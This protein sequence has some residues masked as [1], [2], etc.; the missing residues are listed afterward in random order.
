MNRPDHGSDDADL[1]SRLRERL[2]V[3]PEPPAAMFERTLRRIGSRPGAPAT[4]SWMSAAGWWQALAAPGRFALAAA[5][6][7]VGGTIAF[8]TVKLTREHERALS[9]AAAP[10]IIS[11]DRVAPRTAQLA[12]TATIQ[13]TVVDVPATVRRIAAAARGAGGVVTAPRAADW[14]AQTANPTVRLTLRLP[15]A[16]LDAT[17]RAVA[18]F[19]S[20]RSRSVRSIDL[21]ATLRGTDLQ[22][23]ALRRSSAHT[24][25][26]LRADVHRKIAQLSAHRNALAERVANA[27]LA[28]TLFAGSPPPLAAAPVRRAW[29]EPLNVTLRPTSTTLARGSCF[30]AYGPV[31]VCHRPRALD[32][33]AFGAAPAASPR[34]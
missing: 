12:R 4:P 2:E 9:T 20:V 30:E 19:G 11:M 10:T 13:L 17:L 6:V 32:L 3:A 25:P 16:R 8:D 22:L 23:E 33:A 21:A 24:A 28:V 18:T 27:T 15:A 14:A 34:A 5:I 26:A 7:V 31:V 29:A 1:R